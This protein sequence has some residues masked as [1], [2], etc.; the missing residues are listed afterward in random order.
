MRVAF[1][2]Q[3]ANDHRLLRRFGSNPQPIA[4]AVGLRWPDEARE[5]V[6]Q[7]SVAYVASEQFKPAALDP[8]ELAAYTRAVAVLAPQL[9]KTV[10]DAATQNIVRAINGLAGERELT[11]RQLWA[12]AE[13]VGFIGAR[14]EPEPIQAARDRL[15]LEIAA[16]AS[17]DQDNSRQRGLGRAI[18][19]TA[20]DLGKEERLQAVGYLVPRLGQELNSRSAK[21]IP[22]A[23]RALLPL[24][25]ADQA[26]EVAAAVPR[27]IRQAA[28]AKP[29][30]D[31]AYLL[32]LMQV[33]ETLAGIGDQETI[34]AFGEALAAQLGLPNEPRQQAA[35]ARAAA[36]LL[37]TPGGDTPAV[38]VSVVEASLVPERVV[39]D[40]ALSSYPRRAAY[41]ALR[42]AL[43]ASDG[44]REKGRSQAVLQ[45]LEV[46]WKA[47][48]LAGDR[49]AETMGADREMGSLPKAKPDSYRR[50]AQVRLAAM[51]GP[52][53]PP[54]TATLASADLL[55]MLP[56]TK[57]YVTREAIARALAALAPKLA[58]P[59][60]QE[61]LA[62]AKDSRSPDWF[63]RRSR[64][65]GACGRGAA[66]GRAQDGHRR[67]RRGAKISDSDG[68]VERGPAR[69][70]GER[71]ARGGV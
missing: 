17:T 56:G 4:R 34:A 43:A 69:G 49:E 54:D 2:R 48:S 20:R 64:C 71:L 52:S 41:V 38:I 55:T 31:G 44:E 63:F 61:A 12:L 37:A 7:Q 11:G 57:D 53:L 24:L 15:R 8:F 22:R 68:G 62:A 13:M 30:Q 40:P 19:V 1:V 5:T 65:M 50:A 23:L 60:R 33:V 10:A 6:K 39:L 66:A 59:E 28:V 67:N 45:L 47:K 42:Q 35:L 36:P 51:L 26:L 70:P 18:E 21:S 58:E 46:D 16:A 27:A 9:D 32:S 25:D 29:D 3:L 14:L